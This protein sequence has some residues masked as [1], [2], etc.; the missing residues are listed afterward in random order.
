MSAAPRTPRPPADNVH[1]DAVCFA[2]VRDGDLAALGMLYDRY[3]SDVADTAARAGVLPA[4]LE[5]VVH[6]TF[7]TLVTRAGEYDGRASAR[8][9]ILGVAWRV[10]AGR[11]RSLRR[12]LQALVGLGNHPQPPADDPE[13][14]AARREQRTAF[15]QALAALP[16]KMQAVVVLVEVEGLSGRKQAAPWGFPR[17]RSGRDCTMH[18][19][20]SPRCLNRT[21]KGNRDH[22]TGGV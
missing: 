16:E 13:S 9:W 5:D 7:L 3:H 20:A 10:A 4:D 1:S 18:A 22:G 19:S 2:R 8:P 15:Q 17:R 12:W 6:E 11:R 21:G 14:A